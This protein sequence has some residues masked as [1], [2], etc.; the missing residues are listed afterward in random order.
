MLFEKYFAKKR[1][2]QPVDPIPN[3]EPPPRPVLSAPALSEEDISD[4]ERD[5]ARKIQRLMPDLGEAASAE[6]RTQAFEV[7]E[8]LA[9]DQLPRIRRLVAEAIKDSAK[10]PHA[11]IRNLAEDV[12]LI[13]SAPILEYSPLLSDEDLKEIIAKSQTEGALAAIARRDGLSEDVSDAVAATMDI[14]AV[15]ALLANESAEIRSA[16]L[17]K[18]TESAKCVE[19]WHEPLVFRPELSKRAMQ[20]IAGF[21][22]SSL[23]HVMV[24]NRKLDADFADMLLDMVRARLDHDPG[25]DAAAEKANRLLE[26]GCVDDAYLGDLIDHRRARVVIHLLAGLADIPLAVADRIIE[27]LSPKGVIA[28]VWKAG[29]TMRTALRVQYDVAHISSKNVINA[30]DGVD[31]PL[32]EGEMTWQLSYFTNA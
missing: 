10:V 16:T 2:A 7:L 28:L 20:R 18:I 26:W 11:M 30:K 5:V 27:A 19:E 3:P 31:F 1:P 12:E 6:L 29:F 32:T 24:S 22:A 13:V 14:S 9:N 23:V 21:V 4:I 15:A 25:E 8:T 17:D